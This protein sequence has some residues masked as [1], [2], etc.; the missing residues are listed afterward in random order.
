VTTRGIKP[1]SVHILLGSSST[2]LGQLV[3]NY[4][5]SIAFTTKIKIMIEQPPSVLTRTKRVKRK[6]ENKA[7]SLQIL[8]AIVTLGVEY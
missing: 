6:K 5:L 1:I 4:D 7:R 8:L 2:G 3:I